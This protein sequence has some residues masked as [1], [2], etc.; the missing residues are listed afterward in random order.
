MQRPH[1]ERAKLIAEQ[2][3]DVL[4]E[5]HREVEIP[6]MDSQRIDLWFR[7]LSPGAPEPEHL[8]LLAALFAQDCL[9]EAY[10]QALRLDD[11]WE[12]ERKQLSWGAATTSDWW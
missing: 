7:R 3:L 6:A 2:A 8:R 4:G 10:S 1:D 11:F 5:V 9:I 12:S